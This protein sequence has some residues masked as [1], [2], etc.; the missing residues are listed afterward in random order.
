KRVIADLPEKS[1]VK[2]FCALTRVQA[3]LY[4]QSV[5]WLRGALGTLDGMQRRGIILAFLM[6][7]KQICNHPSQWLGDDD[8]AA[9]ASGKFVRLAEICESIAA[10]QEKVLIFTQFREMTDPLASALERIFGRSGLVLH[11]QTPVRDR[12]A[13]VARFQDDERVP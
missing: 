9:E 10:R 13:L 5:D 2:A 12:S 6:R 3:A 8:Y 7:L 11:G 4:Q 1:E